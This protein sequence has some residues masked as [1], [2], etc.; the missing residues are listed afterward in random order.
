MKRL[1]AGAILLAVFTGP[2]VAQD[3]L[4][5]VP[6]VTLAEA[7]ERS[8][9]LDPDYVG[10]LGTVESAE[11]GRRAARLAFILPSVS[12]GLDVTK[13]S[14]GFFNLGTGELQ[15]TAVTARANANYELFSLRKLAELSRAGAALDAANADE[16][17]ARFAAAL[18]TEQEYYA[19]SWCWTLP[20]RRSSCSGSAP[21]WK[22]PSSISDAGLDRTV[23]W[24]PRPWTPCPRPSCPSMMVPRLRW[25]WNRD[26][27]GAPL[28]PMSAQPMPCCGRSGA[29]ISRR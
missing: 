10:A 19:S 2:A 9:R 3:T 15:S 12:V 16:T 28:V 11:W 26:R 20:G 22:W 18:L 24:M 25:P 17:R 1:L 21:R 14:S 6:V 7:L 4:A 23:R 5:A 29:I 27:P 8:A 13:Y